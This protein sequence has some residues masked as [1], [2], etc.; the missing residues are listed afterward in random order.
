MAYHYYR[1]RILGFLLGALAWGWGATGTVMAD[2]TSAYE[3]PDSIR[4][5]G[6]RAV[7][8]WAIAHSVRISGVDN[9]GEVFYLKLA[10]R[11]AQDLGDSTSLLQAR[12][13]LARRLAIE[14]FYEEA[15]KLTYAGKRDARRLHDT[16]LW[17]DFLWWES[18]TYNAIGEPERA[19]AAAQEAMD[20]QR[21]AGRIDRAWSLNAVGEAYRYAGDYARAMP[22]YREAYDLFVRHPQPDSLEAIRGRMTI[23]GNLAHNHLGQQNYDSVQYYLNEMNARYALSPRVSVMLESNLAQ[24][25]VWRA[26]GKAGAARALAEAMQERARTGKYPKYELQYAEW[27]YTH[28]KARQDFASALRYRERMAEINGRVTMSRAK[29]RMA[30]FE[31]EM[32]NLNL[33]NENEILAVKSRNQSI[34]TWTFAGIILLLIVFF[35]I[36]R[37]NN[38]KMRRLNRLLRT[39]NED[40]DKANRE[41]NGLV[42]IVAHDLKAPL[43]KSMMLTDLIRNS[44][45]TSPEQQ[46]Y[47][48]MIH[49]VCSNGGDLIQ[50]LLEI[51]S[52]EAE[53]SAIKPERFDLV[54]LLQ[55]I[56]AEFQEP[57]ARK[58]IQLVFAPGPTTVPVDTDAHKLQRVI[59]NI[60]SNAIKFT[61][62]GDQVQLSVTEAETHALIQIRDEGPGISPTDREKMFGK[63]QKLTA[64]P[65]AGES[66]HGLGLSIV[67]SLVERLHLGMEMDSQVG[68]GTE[69][70]FAVPR[71]W[72][73]EA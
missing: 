51:S 2:G 18:G 16:L 69:F 5:K 55:R 36:Q 7:V 68:T 72:P 19:V 9:Q 73:G 59:D 22:I 37:S 64:R 8:E 39:R 61:R 50:D 45:A 63:F 60:L 52:L 32:D 66:S 15:L 71:E 42:G 27:L 38:L 40:L 35:V 17:R 62:S 47:L 65:T 25:E 4:G 43:T 49:K 53:R 67:Q 54:Q 56:V 34:Y 48:G 41:I 30:M 46:Q 12:S 24:I 3:L 58:G 70:R 11:I 44:T 20:L 13:R 23:A 28:H 57:A 29:V 33:R 14:G 10:E 26:E 1:Y 6:D 21:N 31:S